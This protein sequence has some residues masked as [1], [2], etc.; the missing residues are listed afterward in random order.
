MGRYLLSRLAAAAATLLAVCATVFAVFQVFPAA[1]AQAICGKGC[2][3]G[4]IASINRAL[5]LDRPL[6]ERFASYL[7]GIVTG[8]DYG[9]GP[10][11]V[12]CSFPCLGFSFQ[13]GATVTSLLGSR[14]AVSASVALGAAVLFLTGGVLVGTAA[15]LRPGSRLDRGLMTAVLAASA[16]PAFLTALVLT[17]LLPGRLGVLPYP[18]YTPLTDA[19]AAWCRGLLLPWLTL[20]AACTAPYA[21]HV[22][23]GLARAM[24][25]DYVRTARAKGAGPLRTAVKHG[26]RPALTPLLTLF[27]LQLARLLGG[28]VVVES[29]FGLPGLGHLL[30]Q[31]VDQADLPVVLGVSLLAAAL[32]LAANLAVDLLHAALDPRART[33][34]GR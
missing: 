17:A 20:A 9:T 16:P 1:P 7:T 31:A 28:T 5:G 26:L 30:I 3:P 2:S 22:R 4:T 13:D 15:A 29:V 6:P 24:A 11:P 23:T 27:G 33:G 25:E 19:P 10:H 18:Q 12:H 34:G 8:R 14:L 21:R 32:V